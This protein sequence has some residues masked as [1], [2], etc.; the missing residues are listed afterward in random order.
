[1]IN[2]RSTDGRVLK[3]RRVSA[4]DGDQWQ[5]V[6]KSSGLSE[7]SCVSLGTFDCKN[8]STDSVSLDADLVV[9]GPRVRVEICSEATGKSVM[10]SVSSTVDMRVLGRVLT[11]Q[12]VIAP[13]EAIR[14]LYNP[15]MHRYV[16]IARDEEC[17]TLD[18]FFM[19]MRLRIGLTPALYMTEKDI[20]HSW[21]YGVDHV[22]PGDVSNSRI[23]MSLAPEVRPFLVYLGEW[24]TPV[25]VLDYSCFS[26]RARVP[27]RHQVLSRRA[28]LLE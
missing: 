17:G 26:R 2:F 19:P 25:P 24:H 13:S 21:P 10:L 7:F 16:D 5:D 28:E 12:M 20:W 22:L 14:P 4:P 6:V 9:V 8:T 3:R 18:D 15:R 11:H 1:M 23:V 27:L